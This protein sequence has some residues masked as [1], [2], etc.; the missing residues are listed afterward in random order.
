M[1]PVPGTG[2]KP[3]AKTAHLLPW[4]S[5]PRMPAQDKQL[6]SEH[7][8]LE[9]GVT[10]CRF[11][12][13]NALARNSIEEL[14]DNP[15]KKAPAPARSAHLPEGRSNFQSLSHWGAL[16]DPAASIQESIPGLDAV[17]ASQGMHW[18]HPQLIFGV[19]PS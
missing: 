7:W 5:Q 15:Q 8:R 16:K 18:Q 12:W 4:L 1:T 9:D 11:F 13:R 3:A 19:G 6:P 14:L 10:V 2:A 17:V